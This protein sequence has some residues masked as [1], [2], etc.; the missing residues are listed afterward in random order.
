MC[1]A[2]FVIQKRFLV[3]SLR[4]TLMLWETQGAHKSVVLV[5]CAVCKAG[6]LNRPIEELK[7]DLYLR[8]LD[9]SMFK[10]RPSSCLLSQSKR[11]IYT[12]TQ[13]H[14]LFS[15]GTKLEHCGLK[16]FENGLE[17]KIL[18]PKKKYVTTLLR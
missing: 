3:G 13:F 12:K 9:S 18:G 15:I 10:T 7:A 5:E 4:K 17:R 16:M 8:M 11:L 14:L 1:A 2:Q 6:A